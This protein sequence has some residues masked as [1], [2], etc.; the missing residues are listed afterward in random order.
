MTRIYITLLLILPT[1]LLGQ[2]NLKSGL[3]ACY[4]FNSN[5]VDATGNGNNGI[6]SG[7]SLTTDRFGKANSAYNFDGNSYISVSPDQFKNQS[8]TYATWVNL[9]VIP[10]EGD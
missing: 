8:Y 2:A 1:L 7:A 5:A 9:D 4:P 3:I 10:T 6:V